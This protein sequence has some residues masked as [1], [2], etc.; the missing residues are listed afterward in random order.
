MAWRIKQGLYFQTREFSALVR[1]GFNRFADSGNSK[2]Y[3]VD[4][5]NLNEDLFY[6]WPTRRQ[7]TKNADQTSEKEHMQ[8]V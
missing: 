3:G 8:K 1:G 7:F 2:K 6:V 4:I 5:T